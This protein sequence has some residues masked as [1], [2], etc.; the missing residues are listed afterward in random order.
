MA[1]LETLERNPTETYCTWDYDRQVIL[2]WSNYRHVIDSWLKQ[3]PEYCKVEVSCGERVASINNVPMSIFLKAS[4]LKK[5]SRNLTQEQR[6]AL[7]DRL[8]ASR[9][10]S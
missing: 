1:D 10:S 3:F 9:S 6:D 8:A 7:R 2:G 5:K 4:N